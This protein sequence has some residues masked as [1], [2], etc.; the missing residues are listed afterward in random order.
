MHEMS[1]ATHLLNLCIENAEK[2]SAKS[3]S[4]II[5][6]IGKLSGVEPHFLTSAFDVIKIDTLAANAD[7]EFIHQEVVAHCDKCSKD[8]EIED[9]YIACP[10]CGNVKVKIIDGEELIL[11]SLELDG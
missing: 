1:V 9:Y 11:M 8:Y 3:I 5:V 7:L 6:K 10:E 4:K 2:N